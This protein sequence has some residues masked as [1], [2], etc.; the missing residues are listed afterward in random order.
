MEH[1][2]KKNT[3]YSYV[4]TVSQCSYCWSSFYSLFFLCALELFYTANIFQSGLQS[5]LADLCFLGACWIPWMTWN[6]QTWLH[7]L[8]AF[9]VATNSTLSLWDVRTRADAV[10]AATEVNIIFSFPFWVWLPQW[11]CCPLDPFK[12]ETFSTGYVLL[13]HRWGGRFIA[14]IYTLQVEAKRHV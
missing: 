2:G 3:E 7:Y 4:H 14:C 11:R 9:W 12:E 6:L 10:L 5:L 8:L 13:K 1:L